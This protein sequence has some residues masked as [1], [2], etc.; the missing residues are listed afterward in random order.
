MSLPRYASPDPYTLEEIRRDYEGAD[1]R[2]R[3][4][5]LRRLGRDVGIPAALV[6]LAVKDENAQVRQ[7]IARFGDLYR[8]HE[9]LLRADQDEFVRACV[10]E[11]SSRHHFKQ[12]YD[13][14]IPP[15]R[16]YSL[17]RSRNPMRRTHPGDAAVCDKRSRPHS[18]SIERSVE[19]RPLEAT[20]GLRRVHGPS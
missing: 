15:S 14:E 5:L 16:N 12:F 13:P 19:N 2:G 18:K 20:N 7:W 3:I 8:E 17:F 4:R 11:N 10:R 6:T 9:E 1:S